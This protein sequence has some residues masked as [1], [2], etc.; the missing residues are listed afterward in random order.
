MKYKL[1]ISFL[2]FVQFSIFAQN[3][4]FSLTG[5]IS[6]IHNEAPIPFVSVQIKELKINTFTDSLGRYTFSKLCSGSYTLICSNIQGYKPLV[7]TI[8]IQENKVLNLSYET[9]LTELTEVNIKAK[10][11]ATKTLRTLQINSIVGDELEKN[12]AT[13][14]GEI[15]KTLPGV[16]TLNSGNSVSKPVIR[17]LHSNRILV[18]NNGIRQEG[19]QWGIEH[20]PEIDPFIADKITVVKGASSTMYGSD[21]IAGVVLIETKDLPDTA[22]INGEINAIGVSNGRGG[23]VSSYLQGVF[24]KLPSFAWRIQ[25]TLKQNG[26]LHTPSYNLINTGLKEYNFSYEL[27]WNKKNFGTQLFYSQFNTTLGIFGASHIGN[28][29]DLTRAFNSTTPL[30][31]STFTYDISRPMQH[32]EHELFKWSGYLATGKIGKLTATYSRQY[33]WRYEFDKHKPLND[34]LAAKNLPDL[35]FHLTTH[36]VDMNWK[37]Y[38]RSNFTGNFGLNYIQQSN[39]FRGR[40]LIP[41]FECNGIGMYGIE[42]WSYKRFE[43]EGGIR[44]DFKELNVYTYNNSIQTKKTHDFQRTSISFGANYNIDSLWNLQFNIGSAWRAPTVNELY[45]NGLHHGAAAV[46]YGNPN[47]TV[48]KAMNYTFTISCMKEEAYHIELSPYMILFENFIYRKPTESPVLTIRGAFPAFEYV[49]T[50][51]SL[52]G[53]DFFGSYHLNSTIE[54]KIKSSLLRAWNTSKNEWLQLMPSD[55]VES[56]IGFHIDRNQKIKHLYIGPSVQY[57]SKQT[58]VPSN[59]DFVAPPAAYWLVNLTAAMHFR[60]GKQHAELGCTV[61]NLTN[62][63]Y[64]DYMDRFRYFADAIGRS[65]SIRLKYKF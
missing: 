60:I 10:V 42:S 48:E 35:E 19:Q 45:S 1:I 33:N 59:A 51:A 65:I 64:R 34:N 27:G 14:L 39:T 6:D 11:E 53:V 54:W 7:K 62:S 55:R 13:N 26:T 49:Q 56:E 57:V 44:L 38:K 21:A 25:G 32:I 41:S 15:L 58:R 20:A 31:T 28:L 18:L 37:H 23:T 2:L 17:G 4:G 12:K 36:T 61:T 5:T 16:N 9:H 24:T 3:C 8:D 40:L 30:E 22:S 63:S 47:L 29:T 43:L 46:E 50:A 52:K